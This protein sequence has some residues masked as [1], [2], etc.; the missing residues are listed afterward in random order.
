MSPNNTVVG[1]LA[2]V[3]LFSLVF[4]MAVHCLL[5]VLVLTPHTCSQSSVSQSCTARLQA[6]CRAGSLSQ[7]GRVHVALSFS[8]VAPEDEVEKLV[9]LQ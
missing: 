6:C 8:S 5:L 4:Q 9:M 3:V 2:N 7:A 1:M